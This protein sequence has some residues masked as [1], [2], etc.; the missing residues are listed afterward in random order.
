MKNFQKQKEEMEQK[1]VRTYFLF[2]VLVKLLRF[3][4]ILFS[5]DK[6]WNKI[7]SSLIL[8]YAWDRPSTSTILVV[9]VFS[10]SYA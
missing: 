8:S 9:G 5:Y 7:V 4:V 3:N 1:A 10:L 2:L 6:C